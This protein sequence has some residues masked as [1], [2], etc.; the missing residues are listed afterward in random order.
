MEIVP[1]TK[2]SWGFMPATRRGWSLNYRPCFRSNQSSKGTKREF[3]EHS[4]HSVPIKDGFLLVEQTLSWELQK[5]T[6]INSFQMRPQGTMN[7]P[8]SGIVFSFFSRWGGSFNQLYS[9]SSDV[10]K[11]FIKKKKKKESAF[12]KHSSTFYKALL[13]WKRCRNDKEKTN[14][15]HRHTI[16]R[17]S[18]LLWTSPFQI[19]YSNSFSI[20]NADNSIRL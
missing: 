20:D 6:S 16:K 18:L 12:T 15:C 11:H 1:E 14:Y 17:H 19:I 7:P 3:V 2:A 8:E 13:K 10:M 9:H 5:K 4:V